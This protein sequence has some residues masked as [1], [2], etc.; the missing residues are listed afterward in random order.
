[1]SALSLSSSFQSIRTRVRNQMEVA[2]DRRD[3]DTAMTDPRVRDEH[4]A[5]RTRAV[6]GGHGDCP[7]CA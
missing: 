4:F 7:F 5:A 1:M 3:H 6:D 2:R